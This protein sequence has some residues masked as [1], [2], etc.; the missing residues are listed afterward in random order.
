MYIKITIS[1]WWC[2]RYHRKLN[3]SLIFI[4]WSL[5]WTVS[6]VHFL[7]KLENWGSFQ[8]QSCLWS[9]CKVM[10]TLVL[11]LNTSYSES[12]ASQYYIK[13]VSVISVQEFTLSTHFWSKREWARTKAE[14]FLIK[15]FSL[16]CKW[17]YAENNISHFPSNLIVSQLSFGRIKL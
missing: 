13:I 9:Y 14:P 2:Q 12:S 3:E 10:D 16:L 4:Q 8:T 17:H 11:Y 1:I 15:H 7:H 5:Y 6:S